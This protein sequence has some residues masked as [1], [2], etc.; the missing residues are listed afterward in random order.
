MRSYLVSL[1]AEWSL[2]KQL[3]LWNVIWSPIVGVQFRD[4]GHVFKT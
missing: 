2:G 3:V 1:V 4:I